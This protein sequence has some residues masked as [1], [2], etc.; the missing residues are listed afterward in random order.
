MD[1][2]NSAII[3]GGLA[4]GLA[5]LQLGLLMPRKFCPK[6]NTVLPRL[7]KPSSGRESM[8]GGWSCKSCNAKIARN[9]TLLPTSDA[10]INSNVISHRKDWFPNR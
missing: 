9:G 2:L 1:V 10:P 8:L 3:I 6:C 4:G 5:V 7:R